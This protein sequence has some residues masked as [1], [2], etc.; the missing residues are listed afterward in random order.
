MSFD[1]NE[2][3]DN[4]VHTIGMGWTVFAIGA[5]DKAEMLKQKQ[6]SFVVESIERFVTRVFLQFLR[7]LSD[8]VLRDC[9]RRRDALKLVEEMSVLQQQFL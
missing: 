8:V 2:P 3:L 1:G 5:M 4:G 7:D 9:A 6:S